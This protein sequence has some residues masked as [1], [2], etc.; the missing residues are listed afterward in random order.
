ML[1]FQNSSS[2]V[3]EPTLS[4]TEIL[5]NNLCP[6]NVCPQHPHPPTPPPCLE[7]CNHYSDF[8]GLSACRP[9]KLQKAKRPRHLVALHCISASF[10][11]FI[12]F[13]LSYDI[14]DVFRKFHLLNRTLQTL[15]K[16]SYK[17]VYFESGSFSIHLF[18]QGW[19]W[20]CSKELFVWQP[21]RW[22]IYA[23]C[24]TSQLQVINLFQLHIMFKHCLSCF[25]FFWRL[26]FYTSLI[27]TLS[28][29]VWS[30]L[31]WLCWELISPLEVYPVKHCVLYDLFE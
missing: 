29:P 7:M 17:K 25:L 5:C 19:H 18:V 8:P 31:G 28:G 21:S 20:C 14:Y 26:S 2:N 3:P 6:E 1:D 16:V 4:L 27:S 30:T 15:S 13:F 23:W 22:Q 11:T 12:Q 9:P 24:W 10:W